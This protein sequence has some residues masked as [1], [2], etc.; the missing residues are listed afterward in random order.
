M[1]F[2]NCAATASG[3]EKSRQMRHDATAGAAAARVATASIW[4][5]EGREL[6]GI[7]GGESGARSFVRFDSKVDP[8]FAYPPDGGGGRR[9]DWAVPLLGCGGDFTGLDG[10]LGGKLGDCWICGTT[11][12][13]LIDLIGA[14]APASL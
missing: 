7:G 12:A 13:D 1:W 11:G 14:T 4:A 5:T 10:S 8:G 2:G 9:R 3:R 6:T